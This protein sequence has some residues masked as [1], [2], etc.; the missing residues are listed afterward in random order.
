MKKAPRF[1]EEAFSIS[2]RQPVFPSQGDGSDVLLVGAGGPP[3][4]SH[5]SFLGIWILVS[6]NLEFHIKVLPFSHL[7]IEH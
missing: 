4:V 3:K 7:N 5:K 6:W 2:A 1:N